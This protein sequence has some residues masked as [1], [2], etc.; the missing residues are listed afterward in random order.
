MSILSDIANN[1]STQRT[2]TGTMLKEYAETNVMVEA[3]ASLR[4]DAYGI[5]PLSNQE[6]GMGQYW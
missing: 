4:N 3:A 5:D 1:D 6:K 2:I